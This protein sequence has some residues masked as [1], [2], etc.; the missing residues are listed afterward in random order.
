MKDV[1][2]GR[3]PK[4]TNEFLINTLNEYLRKIHLRRLNYLN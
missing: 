3:K 4:Y 2:L 1:K